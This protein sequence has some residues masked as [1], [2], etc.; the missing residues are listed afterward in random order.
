MAVNQER[1][2]ELREII[3]NKIADGSVMLS[4]EANQNYNIFWEKFNPEYLK[5]LE[6][7]KIIETISH[8]G[9]KN[10]LTYWL[11]FKNDDEFKTTDNF[12]S[13]AGGSSFKFVMFKRKRDNNWVAGNPQNPD[14]LSLDDA[15]ELGGRI[16]DALIQGAEII[17][18][19]PEEATI[20][21]Y[22]QLQKD[23]DATL[24]NNMSRLGWVHKYYHMIFPKKID[25]WHT[26]RW[27]R[28]MLICCDVLPKFETDLYVLSGQ[29]MQISR[30][31]H[32]RTYLV[33]RAMG[34]LFGEPKNYFRIGTSGNEK[35]YWDEMKNGGYVAIGWSKIGDLSEYEEQTKSKIKTKVKEILSQEYTDNAHTASMLANRIM[36]FYWD[37][38]IGDIVVAGD[39]ESVLGVGQVADEYEYRSDLDF[40]HTYQVDWL[41]FTQTKLPDPTEGLR[42]SVSVYKNMKNILEIEKLIDSEQEELAEKRESA[43]TDTPLVPLH[44]TVAEIKSILSRKKQVIL[45]GPPGTGKTYYAEKACFELAARNQFHRTFDSLSEDEKK[46]IAGNENNRGTVRMC[47]FHPTYGYEDFIEGIKPRVL[48]GQVVFEPTD[49]IF[50]RIC[51]DAI[52]E[53]NKEFYLIIDEINRGDISRVFGEL[54]MLIEK[55]K[56]NKC[57]ILPL[58][59]QGFYVPENVLLVG[60][61]NTADRSIALLDIAL[62][63]RFGFVEL[64]PDYKLFGEREFEGLPLAGWLKELNER[65]CEY[66]GKDAR[67]LQIGHSYFLEKEKTIATNQQFKRIIKEDIIP[68]VEEYCY[69]DYQLLSKILGGGLVDTKNQLVRYELFQTSDISNLITALLAPSPTLRVEEE[70]LEELEDESNGEADE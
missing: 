39:G 15:I 25:T 33:M 30:Q 20:E 55:G 1:V 13:I 54:I 23:L 31:V 17:G 37:I 38:E 61:M 48:N 45:Y 21:E 16:R 66:L 35:S 22:I 46:Q 32:S 6:G 67:N 49:G 34:E 11:E 70:D 5:S 59:N 29:I 65:I 43:S 18:D 63:R 4:E 53:P 14:I 52:A 60:T 28:H 9:N 10:S 56:R 12:G 7:E 40:S 62:R 58:T 47:C 19:L 27:H 64:M 26:T 36:M 51:N 41:N 68:L 57:V 50:K 44:K 42:K 3:E 69:G 8:V 24:T 2:H